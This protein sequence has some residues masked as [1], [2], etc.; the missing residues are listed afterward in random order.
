M[1]FV[2]FQLLQHLLTRSRE[3]RLILF[4]LAWNQALRGNAVLLGIL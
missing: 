4:N 3:L 2:I 1:R